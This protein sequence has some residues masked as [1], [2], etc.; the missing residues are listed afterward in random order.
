MT[1]RKI[2]NWS[3]VMSEPRD[4]E[5]AKRGVNYA[6]EHEVRHWEEKYYKLQKLCGDLELSAARAKW[7]RDD[8]E[9]KLKI[10]LDALEKAS[11]RLI[12]GSR[13]FNPETDSMAMHRAS[14]MALIEMQQA[15]NKIGG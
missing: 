10:A 7:E 6:W 5:S 4:F 12:I 9:K 2:D 1:K 14:Q 3:R 15:L 8:L 13:E 11:S